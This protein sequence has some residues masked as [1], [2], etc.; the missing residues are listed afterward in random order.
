MDNDNKYLLADAKRTDRIMAVLWLGFIV[1]GIAIFGVLIYKIVT[2]QDN[3]KTHNQFYP[4]PVEKTVFPR[5]GDIT[6]CRDRVLATSNMVYDIHL[7]CKVCSDAVWNL[8]IKA[9]ADSLAVVPGQRN[10]NQ[11]FQYLNMGRKNKR[12]GLVIGRDISHTDLL[13]ISGYPIFKQGRFKGG[14]VIKEREQRFYP[15]DKVARRTIGYVKNN[16][17]NIVENKKIGIEG[18]CDDYLHGING[19]SIL[20]KSDFGLI[21]ISEDSNIPAIAGKTVRTTLDIDIQSISDRAL[22]K[23]VQENE[24]IEKSCVIVLESSTGAIRA[25]VNLG[26]DDWG[27]IY[28][29]DNYAV[30]NAEAPGSVFKGAVVMA[31]LEEGYLTTL[32]T[33]I[34]TYGG[35]WEYNG[36]KFDDR[37]HVGK[38]RYPSGYIKVK[39]A[40]EMSA[41]NPFRQLICD[42]KHFG[43]NPARFVDRVKSFGLFDTLDFDLPGIAKP[44]ILDPSIKKMTNKGFWDAGTFPRMAIGYGMELSPL[45]IVTFYNAIANRGVMYKPYLV[46][47][48]INGKKVEKQFSPTVLHE[49]ICRKEVADTLAKVMGKVAS[50]RNGTAYW[51]LKDAVCPIAGK[52]GTAQRVFRGKNGKYVMHE[53]DGTE[54]QQGSF[55]GFFPKDKP[56]YTAIVVVWGKPSKKNLFGATWAAPVFREIADKIYSL[57]D[58]RQLQ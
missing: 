23:V 35:I 44:F 13:R 25:M 30:K 11:W 19:C 34:P 18:A 20:R 36:F 2:Y 33:K 52:T 56:E 39:E 53:P 17:E 6:D 10:A 45:N 58:G 51:Q 32:E 26:R 1:A 42:E 5:R 41:N 27:N 54:S 46:D 4:V 9:L 40:F 49:G 15:Y 22:R 8:S 38:D 29:M 55:V 50:D 14:V 21:P 47:A 3:P 24:L 43:N 37:K 28:E 12:G 16:E 7:D 31:M 57:N 48:I